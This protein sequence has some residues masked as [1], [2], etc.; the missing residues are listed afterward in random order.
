MAERLFQRLGH[1]YIL[2]MMILTRLFGAAGGLLVI[3]YMELTQKLPHPVHLHFWVTCVVV[4][5]IAIG[6]SLALAMW[7][8]RHLRPVL[9]RLRAGETV[10][11]AEKA[12]AGREAVTLPAR[13]H[14]HEAWFVPCTT[15]VPVIVILKVLDDIPFAVIENITATCFMAIAMAVMSHF[16]ATDRCIQP[17]IRYLLD[18]GVSI[19]YKSLPVGKLRFRMN[20]CFILMIM[21]TALMIGTLARQRTADIIQE[22]ENQA[23]AVASLRAHS[24]YITIAAV[25]TGILFSTVLA[26][27]VASRVNN[28][29]QA[30]ERVQGGNLSERVQPTSNDEIDI[31]ARQFNAMVQQLEHNDQTIRDLNMNLERKVAERTGELEVTV[32]ELKQTQNRLTEYNEKLESARSQAEAASQAKSDFV[33]SISHELRTPLNGVIGMTELLLDTSLNSHQRKYVKTVRSSGETLLTLIN[34]ILDFSKIEAGMLELEQIEFDLLNVVETVI[35]VIAHRCREKALELVCFVDPGIPRQLRGDP[36][37][38]RQVLTNLANN[39]VKF[40]EE[41]EVV[42]LV[43]LL[44]TTADGV[45]VRFAVRDT[46]IGIAPD[47]FDR[48]FQPFSQLDAST[49]RK[50]GG[51]GLGLTICKQLC[52]LMGGQ[53]GVESALGEGSIFWFTLTFEEAPQGEPQRRPLLTRP[54]GLR[55]LAVDDNGAS[56]GMLEHQL[57][58]WGFDTETARDGEHALEVLRKAAAAQHPFR[59]ALLDMEMP[60]M[61]GRQLA[62]AIR[63]VPML[64]ETALIMLTPLGSHVDVSQ[65]RSAGLTDYVTKPVM[66]SEL[67]DTIMRA[68]APVAPDG[69]TTGLDLRGIESGERHRFPRAKRRGIRILL[70]EDNEVNQE[71]AVQM[72]TKAGYRCDVVND[73]R[74]AVEALQQTRYDAIL[75]DCHMPEMDGLE[76]TRVIRRSE[77]SGN[78]ASRDEI[79]IIALTANAMQSDRQRCLDAGMSDYLSKPLNPIKLIETIEACLQQLDVPPAATQHGR[80]NGCHDSTPPDGSTLARADPVSKEVLDFDAL[81]ARCL[82]DADLAERLLTKFQQRTP[83]DLVEIEASIDAGDLKKVASLAHALKGAAANLSAPALREVAA[84][85]ETAERS[86]DLDRARACLG[87]LQ[88]EWQRFLGQLP[89]VL[90]DASVRAPE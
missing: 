43:S 16:F 61:D 63:T 62:K 32:N 72:L 40:T 5:A 73:G 11:P 21:T 86:T 75:M 18:H 41:G 24:T 56:R 6:I 1:H 23:E 55:I 87:R 74:Q 66:P 81:L 67:F 52:E 8:T 26:K 10:D 68:I 15:Y 7:E 65:L 35:E 42:V 85:L 45:A 77:Q 50:Y 89:S 4:V 2:V 17:V 57:T 53:I 34:E 51:T 36:A 37:R 38:L 76:A 83:H 19:D 25:L 39:A 88:T 33:A 59:I 71:V 29:V 58:A 31:L 12:K 64:K 13:H 84:R 82:G 46:G 30:M 70:A 69:T 22:P 60:G 47:R 49:T 90:A 9:R 20:L 48:L 54:Q 44:E 3:Y 28:L 14:R 79:P 80:T 78:T 27:S